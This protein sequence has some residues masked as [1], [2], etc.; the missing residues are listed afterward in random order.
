MT[1]EQYD[2]LTAEVDAIADAVLSRI[3][4]AFSWKLT[5]EEKK[6]L[7]SAPI[8]AADNELRKYTPS[9]MDVRR[10]LVLKGVAEL[11]LSLRDLKKSI[12][13]GYDAGE[14]A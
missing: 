13:I 3:E 14:N 11:M 5:K 7:L 12:N 10:E 6:V 9:G 1:E 8:Y 2:I 4:S